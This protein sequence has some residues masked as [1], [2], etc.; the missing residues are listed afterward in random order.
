MGNYS[1]VLTSI[2]TGSAT[3]SQ[4]IEVEFWRFKNAIQTTSQ[5][6]VPAAEEGRAVVA[7]TDAT[8]QKQNEK[9]FV[10][11][12]A[13]KA[14]EAKEQEETNDHAGDSFG[15]RASMSRRPT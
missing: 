10:K 2:V 14:E 15:G 13:L 11:L 1:V 8:R 3:S 9:L 7:P 12:Y 5:M 4:I 6:V